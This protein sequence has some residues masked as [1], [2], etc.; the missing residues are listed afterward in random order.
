[1]TATVGILGAG[2]WGTAL[3][4]AAARA[5]NRVVLW[6]RDPDRCRAIESSRENACFLPGVRL[7]PAVRCTGAAVD[8]TA[9]DLILAAVPA[10]ALRDVLHVTG[11]SFSPG[12]PIVIC[13]KGIEQ[14]TG[15]LMS[16][17]VRATLPNNPPAALS[18]PSFAADVA[19]GL[20]TALTL[21]AGT[22]P[23]ASALVDRLGSPGLRLYHSDDLVGVELGGAI[24]NV[25][26]IACGIAHGRGLGASAGAALMARAFAELLR[27]GR[28]S[29]ARP[30]TLM[31]LSGF[32]DLVLTCG[33]AQSR[34]FALGL[35]LGRGEDRQAAGGGRL[36]EGVATAPILLAKAR[37]LAIPMPI[38]ESVAA[39]LAGRLAVEAAIDML[40]ARPA[41]P[42]SL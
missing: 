38:V 20:P 36:A 12:V 24:K 34:N 37:T 39:I 8:L 21:A 22:A 17:V 35:A 4:V 18:G 32:G 16:D 19:R 7:A 1:M 27:F 3:A 9:T 31:G 6:G 13:A 15:L 10:Q 41:G 42:E 14:E 30:E 29:G 5:G 25:L 11:R 40:L 28:A 2:A 33:S 26:A 23:E